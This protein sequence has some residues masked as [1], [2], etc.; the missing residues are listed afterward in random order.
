MAT[1]TVYTAARMKAIEDASIVNGQVVEDNLILQRFD[2][3]FLDA[4]NVRGPQGVK[5]DTGDVSEEQL[6]DAVSALE[7]ADSGLDSRLDVAEATLTN[8]GGRL[9]S[10]ED[11]NT[12]QTGNIA[13][14]TSQISTLNGQLPL[15]SLGLVSS[16]TYWPAVSLNDGA[17]L[18]PVGY[19]FVNGR[20]YKIDVVF[21]DCY[22]ASGFPGWQATV[23]T[24]STT[25]AN[26]RFIPPA[27]TAGWSSRALPPTYFTASAAHTAYSVTLSRITGSGVIELGNIG[28]TPAIKIDVVDLGA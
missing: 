20:K 9:T 22:V 16:Y 18:G 26:L 24:D 6:N 10:V 27:G 19:S 23:L 2:G 21:G 15:R 8:H 1:V 4:G 28:A 12:T 5:G 14:H 11:V 17:V 13:T 25:R 3:S 7:L